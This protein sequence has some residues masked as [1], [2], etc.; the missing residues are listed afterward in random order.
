[1]AT[2]R[3][4]SSVPRRRR[5]AGQGYRLLI[6]SL[7][8]AVAME[9]AAV[10][11]SAPALRVW[12]WALPLASTLRTGPEP[13]LLAQD[14]ANDFVRS[15]HSGRLSASIRPWVCGSKVAASA[16]GASASS[17][18]RDEL[19]ELRAE[20]ARVRQELAASHN[21]ESTL[22][23]ELAMMADR[24]ERG[25]G[26]APEDIFEYPSARRGSKDYSP[27]AVE[28]FLKRLRGEVDASEEFRILRRS[29]SSGRW[30]LYTAGG[31]VK[32]P[33]Q[34]DQGPQHRRA[35][36][37]PS[38]DPKCPFCKGNERNTPDTIF[39]LCANGTLVPGPDLPTEWATRV[40]PNIFPI[41]VT[42]EGAYGEEYQRH[43]AGIPHSEAASGHHG[44]R[45][46]YVR[47]SRS[48]P[49][50]DAVGYSEVVI[51]GM[52]HN[53][54]LALV[55]ASQVALSLKSLQARGRALRHE[56]M[57]KQLL[58]FKQYGE[59]S[60]GS[61]VHP[62]MQLISL[63]IVSPE[64]EQ[65]MFRACRMRKVFGRC[66]SCA[67]LIEEP[68]MN[69][70]DSPASRLLYESRDFV[71]IVPS[72]GPEYRVS[73]V[74]KTHRHSWLDCEE[75]EVDDLAWLL[76][77]VMEAIF[78][79][80]SDPSYDLYI[81]SLDTAAMLEVFEDLPEA[82]HWTL[83]VQPRFPADLGGVELA[84]GIRVIS[85]LPEDFARDLRRG[86]KARLAMRGPEGAAL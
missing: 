72:A 70:T 4:D 74:P 58:H 54:L 2:M 22:Q 12:T 26:P 7:V 11:V 21:R 48:M 55:N 18:A 8:S 52:A 46:T 3:I 71:A 50:I 1:M 75:A 67:C 6:L 77:L 30:T 57:V 42:P 24:M 62:H 79:E 36:Q 23:G 56:P 68:L 28:R 63:P 32:K 5:L 53:G 17:S 73:I 41:M 27:E 59:L 29:I 81:R 45:M 51:E 35:D 14:T 16:L 19:V 80:L 31:A 40:I 9:L 65:Q 15:G 69:R 13:L 78:H 60:G 76:Q 49:Q 47:K 85:G 20:L 33:H 10:C 86:L 61:L 39:S 82:F 25:L 66:S 38:H 64:M 84:S 44:N 34:Y 43:L 83:E 37:Q